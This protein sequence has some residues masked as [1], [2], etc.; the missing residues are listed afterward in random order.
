MRKRYKFCGVA[1]LFPFHVSGVL[2][3]VKEKRQ[4]RIPNPLPQPIHITPTTYSRV[5]LDSNL[6][7]AISSPFHLF[8]FFIFIFRMVRPQSQIH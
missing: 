3:F 1:K 5:I 8:P 4:D 6:F 2:R 7:V